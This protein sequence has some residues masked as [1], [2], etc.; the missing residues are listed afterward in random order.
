MFKVEQGFFLPEPEFWRFRAEP[1]TQA[2]D[3]R[4][5]VDDWQILLRA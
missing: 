5:I 3:K 4:G 1:A 2:F